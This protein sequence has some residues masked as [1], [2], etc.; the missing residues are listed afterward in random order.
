MIGQCAPVRPRN[1]SNGADFADLRGDV[2]RNVPARLLNLEAT[3]HYL[4]LSRWSVRDLEVA[5]VLKRVAIPL[6]G[7]RELRRLLFDRQDL[8]DLVARWKV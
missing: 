2:P 4:S 1:P 5:G 6:P 8:D 7:G 3:A